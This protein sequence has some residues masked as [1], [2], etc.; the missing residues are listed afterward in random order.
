MRLV[1]PRYPAQADAAMV[2]N[3]ERT[4]ARGG[5]QLIAAIKPAVTKILAQG[6]TVS[7]KTFI[8]GM[9]HTAIRAGHT[10][11]GDVNL[12]VQLLRQPYTGALPLQ[13]G[14]AVRELLAF[15]TSPENHE[16]RQRLGLAIG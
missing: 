14:D 7:V 10:L 9:E 4:L 16:L 5:P 1:E 13:Y 3:F 6:R 8:E 11:A 12:V 2:Q 15:V